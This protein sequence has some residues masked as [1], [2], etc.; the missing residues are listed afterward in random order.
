[1]IFPS[2]TSLQRMGQP[3]VS[4]PAVWVD[5]YLVRP[6][7]M[8]VFVPSM[9]IVS[10]IVLS[11][12]HTETSNKQI[13]W[14]ILVSGEEVISSW[15]SLGTDGALSSSPCPCLGSSLLLPESCVTVSVTAQ[16]PL[17]LAPTPPADVHQPL[18]P[19]ASNRPI[20]PSVLLLP[21]PAVSL[22]S[23]SSL[24]KSVLTPNTL[25]PSIILSRHRPP[26][27]FSLSRPP[28]LSPPPHNFSLCRPTLC[29][30]SIHP[31]FIYSIAMINS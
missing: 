18:P 5:P 21:L 16:L 11:R 31:I 3:S 8:F 17:T 2:S 14:Q 27:T 15:Q 13:I 26:L 7:N 23:A 19:V 9:L 29:R 6:S 12:A 4:L 10:S 22:R 30:A 28:P 20:P 25:Q 1:M 24:L